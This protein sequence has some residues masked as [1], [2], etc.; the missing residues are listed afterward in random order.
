[1]L[2]RFIVYLAKAEVEQPTSFSEIAVTPELLCEDLIGLRRT[3][4]MSVVALWSSQSSFL[5]T[6]R[7]MLFKRRISEQLSV[8]LG[9]HVYSVFED[10]TGA[11]YEKAP[12]DT[13]L[14]LTDFFPEI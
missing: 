2:L 3:Q 8:S 11:C 14:F 13:P 10:V 6:Q 1:M 7:R 9:H 4:S 5:L 12:Q